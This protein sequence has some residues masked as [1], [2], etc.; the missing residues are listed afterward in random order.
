MIAELIAFCAALFYGFMY[1]FDK[2]GLRN[3]DPLSA[4]LI[5]LIMSSITL[6]LLLLFS[7]PP[8]IRMNSVMYFFLAGAFSSITSVLMPIGIRKLGVATHAPIQCS[9]PLFS[10]IMAVVILHETFSPW[11]YVGTCL[12]IIGIVFLSYRGEGGKDGW[13]RIELLYPLISAVTIGAT[14]TLMKMGLTILDSPTFA[15]FVTITAALG[16]YLFFLMAS[17]KLKLSSLNKRS[18]V[19][20]S[21]SGISWSL[22]ATLLAYALRMGEITIITPLVSTES[23][24]AMVLSYLFLRDVEIM[25]LRIVLCAIIIALGVIFITAFK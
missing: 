21:L 25:S 6:S 3:S 9:Y 10:T 24:F 8:V 11:V 1:I 12:I 18:F 13:S 19:F 2:K 7:L 23:L 14:I 16:F 15:S 4:S 17:R 20:F 5:R 22:A